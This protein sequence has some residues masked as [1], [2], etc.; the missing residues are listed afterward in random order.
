MIVYGSS[1]S[2]YVRKTLAVAAEKG[3]EVESRASRE[4]E[5]AFLAASPFRKIP[6]MVDGDF[7]ICDSSAIIAYFEAIKPE[8]AM[9]PAEA[10]DRARVVWYE[11][12][13]DS[14][15]VAAATPMFLNRIVKPRFMGLPGDEAAAAKCEAEDTP[16]VLDYLETIVPEAGGFLVGDRLTLADLSVAS[17]FANLEYLKFDLSRWPRTKAWTD[18]I[19]ARPS[20][21]PL[22]VRERAMMAA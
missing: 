12:F 9:I 20:F 7:S 13:A 16:R 14:I 17:P 18:S 21:A 2:P 11:E 1:L 19:L 6:A 8:P 15:L 22:L 3:I 10:K 4:P 5:P